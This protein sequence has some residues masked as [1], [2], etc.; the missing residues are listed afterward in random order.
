M[1][2]FVTAYTSKFLVLGP[3]EKPW[4]VRQVGFGG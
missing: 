2:L 3:K 4:Q 1:T